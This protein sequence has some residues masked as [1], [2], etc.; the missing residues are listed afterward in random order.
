M[1]IRNV[2]N[3]SGIVITVSGR[4]LRAG[5]GQAGA[6]AVFHDITDRRA[7]DARIAAADEVV[8]ADL[9]SRTAAEAN[10]RV[11]RDELADQKAYLDQ[12]INA[13][14]VSVI[15]VTPPAPSFTPTAPHAGRCE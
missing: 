4:P 1:V 9:A 6:V 8:R 14:D 10:L 11:A 2:A 12:V 15:P 5:A 7:A 3:P 13:I